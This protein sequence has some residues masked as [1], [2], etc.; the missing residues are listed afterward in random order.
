[1]NEIHAHLTVCA[2]EAARVTRGVTPG[3]LTEPSVCADWTVRELANHLV[4]YSAHG[5][6]HRA[7]RTPLPEETVQRDFTAEADW[8]ERYAAQ[9][10]R[11]LAA[12]AKPEAWEGEVDLGGTLIAAPEIAS[13]LVK[14]LALH[15]WD[16]AESTGGRFAVPEDT[17]AFLLDVVERYAEVFR[18][19]EGFAAPVAVPDGA[20]AFTRALALSG[21]TPA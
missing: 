21:R 18:Q 12:W 6:E 13:L 15:G 20:D 8:P 4:L 10:D 9:L 16:L 11:A 14:E 17:A 7:L 3:Q 5:L 19:Y 2:A 1:M